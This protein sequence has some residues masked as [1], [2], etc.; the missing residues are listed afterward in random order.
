MFSATTNKQQHLKTNYMKESM[1]HTQRNETKYKMWTY[2]CVHQTHT[3]DFAVFKDQLAGVWSSHAE[4]VELLRCVETWHSLKHTNIHEQTKPPFLNHRFKFL[5][6]NSV[7]YSF[8]QNSK[9]RTEL[10]LTELSRFDRTW[11][12]GVLVRFISLVSHNPWRRMGFHKGD[13]WTWD[14]LL[15]GSSLTVR[16]SETDS[17]TY[18][19]NI[20]NSIC[21]QGSEICSCLI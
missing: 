16:T 6:H 3:W 4:F 7:S 13:D 12:V 2:E 17:N 15:G 5:S 19:K 10:S 1:T 14:I 18:T 8:W 11:S 21:H 9:L 20:S